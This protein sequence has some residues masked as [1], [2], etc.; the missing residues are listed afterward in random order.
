MTELIT[1]LMNNI[2]SKNYSLILLFILVYVSIW[3]YNEFR[4]SYINTKSRN[5]EI[6][7]KT[8]EQYGELYIGIMLF[9][10]KKIDLKEMF[11]YTN[12][13]FTYLS[14]HA[15]DK[16]LNLGDGIK[17]DSPAIEEIKILIKNEISSLKRN[18]NNIKKFDYKE[19]VFEQIS[20]F[21][22]NNGFDSFTYPLIHS[23]LA[24]AAI[25][26][27][28]ALMI[29][30]IEQPWI[31]Q[32]SILLYIVNVVFA[33]F[34][35]INI[36]TLFINKNIKDRTCL[37]FL[38]LII[39]PLAITSIFIFFLPINIDTA[40]TCELLLKRLAPIILNII[41]TITFVFIAGKKE[42][43]RPNYQ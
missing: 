28:I 33:S 15:T 39:A 11:E 21:F 34:I 26:Y 17:F 37:Y 20:W 31:I 19:D 30:L 36:L 18:Q 12:K 7:E 4:K 38:S 10:D 43:L 29:V 1:I 9:Q 23:L 41:M 24:L 35:F 42:L 2:Q 14:K 27:V 32:A 13:T 3:L 6:I 5:I 16:I 25:M 22:Y 40:T 8:L